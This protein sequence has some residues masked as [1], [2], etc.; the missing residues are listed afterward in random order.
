MHNVRK[1]S[2]TRLDISTEALSVI[3]LSIAPLFQMTSSRVF[4]NSFEL[5]I[6]KTPRTSDFRPTKTWAIVWPL[7]LMAA[8]WE[9]TVSYTTGSLRLQTSCAGYGDWMVCWIL[10]PDMILVA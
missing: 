10:C 4:T 7:V 1:M 8:V 2:L 3:N 9:K 6:R 5:D